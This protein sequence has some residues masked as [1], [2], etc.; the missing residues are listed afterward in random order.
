VTRKI[1]SG[2]K[3][4][5]LSALFCLLFTAVSAAGLKDQVF[6]KIL[7]NGLKVILLE[8][9]KAP[10]ITF[11]VWYR[12]GSRN[13][14][15]GRTGLS[16]MLEHMMFKGSKR[17]SA[18]EFTRLIA[19]NGGNDNAFTSED[20]T[21]YFENM[22][23]EKVQVL[24]DLESDRMHNLVLRDEDFQTERMVV[25]EERR[26][27]TEDDPQSYLMEQVQATAFQ[28]SP[29]HWPTIG[30]EQDIDRFTLEDLKSYYGTYYNPVNAI[31][32]VV[33]DFRKEDLLPRIEK[34]FEAIPKGAAP[35]Q[36]KDIDP[37]QTG[38]RSVYARR[39]AELPYLVMAYHVPNLRS[40][41]SY[42]LEVL[43][44]L[45][46][47]GKSS[48]LYRSLVQEK[49]LALSV[50]ADNSLLSRD[51]SLFTLSAQP[52]PEKDVIEV[53]K[54]L[55]EEIERLRKEPV[56]RNE[57]DKARNQL[58]AAFVYGQA[59][60]FYQGMLL[61]Q[62]EIA[63]DWRSVDDYIPSIRRVT[64]EDIHRV[65]NLYLT[66]DN[67]TVGRL[68]PLPPQEGKPAPKESPPPGRMIR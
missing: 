8:N 65:V 43:A 23:S 21:A 49:Q 40:S 39:E 11:Q 48:R 25:M 28:A 16:H 7:P 37:S 67:R 44:A 34:A 42:A 24:I 66:A 60:L 53:E 57:L 56:D 51:P 68:I 35:D 17:F 6:E 46:S 15:W 62:H 29:Y 63:L 54:A 30:W 41:D 18:Q 3:S 12:V 27:R 45:L 38:E 20:F 47:G 32:V 5:F 36:K 26:M 14:Q 50:D 55:N 59:S 22:S 13:E 58:E 33:G 61:A 4:I 19:E 10:V 1:T 52:L 9:H 64:P 2:L 31:L